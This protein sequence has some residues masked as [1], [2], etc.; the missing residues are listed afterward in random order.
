MESLQQVNG[1]NK[2]H[3]KYTR[4]STPGKRWNC[5]RF[6]PQ[7]AVLVSLVILIA[8]VIGLIT[9]KLSTTSH[10]S[11]ASKQDILEL[12]LL[13]NKSLDNIIQQLDD[14]KSCNNSHALNLQDQVSAI[15]EQ[16]RDM[17]SIN[18]T[19]SS[20]IDTIQRN[21]SDLRELACTL[22]KQVYSPTRIDNLNKDVDRNMTELTKKVSRLEGLAANLSS[23]QQE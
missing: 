23:A 7:F 16:L 10:D 21:M 11:F 22:Q 1:N 15:Q 20:Q 4:F 3:K 6:K 9:F 2:W 13:M 5:R 14:Q 8:A 18:D 17:Q 19:L 12:Q